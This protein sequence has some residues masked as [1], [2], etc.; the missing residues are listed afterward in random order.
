MEKQVKIAF[1]GFLVAVSALFLPAQAHADWG[2]HDRHHH[3][4]YRVHHPYP[5]YGKV[6]VSLPRGYVSLRIGGGRY[7]YAD[8]VYYNRIRP[9]QYVVV[10]PPA[11]AVIAA[12]PDNYQPVVI[13]GVAY[14]VNDGIYYQATPQGYLVVAQPATT[15]VT[16]TT[17][18]PAGAPL[19]AQQIP[20]E[21]TVNVPNGHDG[22]TAVTLKQSGTGYLGPQGEFYQSF[23]SVEQL[24]AM[25]VK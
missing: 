21:Y 4:S 3:R 14:Y 5:S 6:Y 2:Y 17:T 19:P 10:A 20:G 7:Y 24:K 22:Y 11:G 23:P 9:R 1:T 12:L 15:V 16:T 25:Y 18:V 13:N 8:G